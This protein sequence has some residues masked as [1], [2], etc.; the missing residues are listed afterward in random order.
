MKY[1][2]NV[3][4]DNLSGKITIFT[5]LMAIFIFQIPFSNMCYHFHY[6]KHIKNLF[7]RFVY[8]HPHCSLSQGIMKLDNP[9]D[10]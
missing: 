4:N 2:K 9:E 7:Q 5:F 1:A 3:H 10:R 8:S 6:H